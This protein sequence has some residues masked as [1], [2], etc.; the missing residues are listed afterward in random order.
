M[1]G[2]KPGDWVETVQPESEDYNES[3]D[4]AVHSKN[5][6]LDGVFLLG[7]DADKETVQKSEELHVLMDQ[8][9]HVQHLLKRSE[10]RRHEA[11]ADLKETS[12]RNDQK[13]RSLRAKIK[14]Q[15]SMNKKVRK[16]PKENEVLPLGLRFVIG[17]VKS[18]LKGMP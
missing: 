12:T 14:A 3:L 13:E 11:L 4:Q 18:T 7:E 15:E 17:W 1:V 2:P 8:L 16:P 6:S 10:I 5:R 9:Y